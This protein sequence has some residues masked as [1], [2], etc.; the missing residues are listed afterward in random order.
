M[1]T[2]PS[3]RVAPQNAPAFLLAALLF[4]VI[5]CFGTPAGAFED[6]SVD[7]SRATGGSRP[8]GADTPSMEAPSSG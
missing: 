4:A 1:R 5:F 6:E 3:V 8:D 7:P 2:R